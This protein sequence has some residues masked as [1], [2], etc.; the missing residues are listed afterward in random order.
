M[1]CYLS[2]QHIKF[3]LTPIIHIRSRGAGWLA[4]TFEVTPPISAY[5]LG[6]FV[7]EYDYQERVTTRG[8]VVRDCVI[9]C[10]QNLSTRLSKVSI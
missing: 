5:R 7:G 8:T 4:D 2:H 9:S 6:F 1:T 3:Y 10:C